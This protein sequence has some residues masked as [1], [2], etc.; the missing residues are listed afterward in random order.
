MALKREVFEIE[1]DVP[2][3]QSAECGFEF[4]N[5]DDSESDSGA[6]FI[7]DDSHTNTEADLDPEVIFVKNN[8]HAASGQPQLQKT[9]GPTYVESIKWPWTVVKRYRI[10]GI[11]TVVTENDTVEL[12]DTVHRDTQQLNSG[13]FVR[14]KQ[15]LLNMLTHE[16]R[17][18]G[19]RLKRTKYHG[20]I[21]DWKLNELV[22]ILRVAEVDQDSP[23]IQGLEDFSLKD[24]L[25]K[26]DCVV[27]QKPYPMLSFRENMSQYKMEKD[28]L[29]EFLFHQGPLVCRAVHIVYITQTG[30]DY[31]GIIRRIYGHEADEIRTSTDPS[32]SI[33]SSNECEE[34]SGCLI[35]IPV[36]SATNKR[37]DHTPS[38]KEKDSSSKL[39]PSLPLK[40]KIYTF[41]DVFCGAGGAS[42]GA[43]N[44]G[45]VIKWGLDH[46]ELAIQAFATNYPQAFTFNID[47]HD[48]PDMK[49][50]RDLLRV[51]ILHLSPPCCYWS[52]A[53]T[54]V[55]QN[56]QANFE[57]IYTVGPILRKVKPRVATLEQTFGLLTS[58]EHQKN[59]K[60]LMYD[61]LNA[62]YDVRYKIANMAEY[63][64]PQRR[65]RLLIIAARRGT[66]LP[67][68]PKPTHG[69]AGSGLKRFTSVYDALLPIRCSIASG[70][71]THDEYHQPKQMNH[72]NKDPYDPHNSM[73]PGCITTGGGGNYHY[74]GHRRYTAR[75]MSL[76]QSFSLTYIF[77]GS[78]TEALKQIGNAFP[79]IMAESMYCVIAQTLEAYDN[80][81]IGA[82]EEIN[83]LQ[84]HLE[85][86]NIRL[87]EPPKS[88]VSLLGD[89]LSSP[90]QSQTPQSPYR[91]L[92]RS[93]SSSNSSSPST[94]RK[95]S[96][97]F[98]RGNA[99][100][101]RK[102]H[103]RKAKKR[104]F[105]GLFDENDN[106]NA[107][108]DGDY[109]D[110]VVIDEL[111]PQRKKLRG[112]DLPL[113]RRTVREPKVED[114]YVVISD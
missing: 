47:A 65:K 27:T 57:A 59:F 56:D 107:N 32:L 18:R 22:M 39:R 77:T 1:D 88:T 111:Q 53:H 13:D 80:G 33:H 12:K 58:V 34:D 63:G 95:K 15:I 97:L 42:T 49:D 61:M 78:N 16:V 35:D 75:E 7:D 85:S 25:R 26:R 8:P 87:P 23:F 6:V 54:N 51:D 94:P 37:C 100:E 74:S 82:E 52:P 103:V 43:S 105:F 28:L 36:L 3:I 102:A 93:V 89:C 91:Y 73:L 64:L 86:K 41:G 96:A 38:F 9:H 101:P 48:F 84:A 113:G 45:L 29:K 66:P 71:A 98:S 50:F 110:F 10:N 2:Q 5:I 106:A 62:G 46:D 24:V 109:D 55:G 20:P 108:V 83:D 76:F 30:K 69:D 67:P 92:H 14:I 68:F 60:L 112:I 114:E 21:F 4:L 31:S 90:S 81:L 19:H 99:I 72:T 79:P 11:E 17:L 104:L 40:N 70:T 44:A